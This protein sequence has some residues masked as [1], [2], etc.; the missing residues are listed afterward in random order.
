MWSSSDRS[1]I[2]VAVFDTKPYDREPLQRASTGSAIEWRF[3]EFR[4]SREGFGVGHAPDGEKALAALREPPLPDLIIL[5]VLLPFMNGF[6]VLA[7]IRADPAWADIPVV[8]L[9][10]NTR[11]ED[12]LRGL[13]SG[14]NDY[15][16]KP[17]R[18]PELIA[19]IRG[20][21]ARKSP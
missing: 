6:E 5:D 7:R 4:L 13:R 16:T 1:M 3:L 20:L 9:T 12:V 18:P 17:F 8:M 10:S 15:L 21:L 19:R 14:A 11:E 2:T